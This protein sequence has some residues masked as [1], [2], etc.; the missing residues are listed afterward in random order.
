MQVSPLR[1]LHFAPDR[2]GV[3]YWPFVGRAGCRVAVN[4]LF[5]RM[6]VM[7]EVLVWRQDAN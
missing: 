3:F 7:S 5:D 4:G 2:S 1:W 6:F